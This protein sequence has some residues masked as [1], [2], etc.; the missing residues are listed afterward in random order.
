MMMT[1]PKDFPL[2]EFDLRPEC[3]VEFHCP[4]CGSV[5]FHGEAIMTGFGSCDWSVVCLTCGWHVTE[6]FRGTDDYTN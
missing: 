3:W 6:T 4:E 2:A 1:K 5:D